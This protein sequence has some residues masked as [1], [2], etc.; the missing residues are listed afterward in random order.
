L[1]NYFKYFLILI[2]DLFLFSKAKAQCDLLDPTYID[3]VSVDPETGNIHISWYQNPSNYTV[4]YQILMHNPAMNPVWN[5]ISTNTGASNIYNLLSGFNTAEKSFLFNVTAIDACGEKSPFSFGISHSTI[6]VSNEYNPCERSIKL[7][8]NQYINWTAGVGRYEIWKKENNIHTLVATTNNGDTTYT[9]TGVTLFTNL[10]LYIRA[11]DNSSPSKTSTSN[12]TSVFTDFPRNP[13]FSYIRHASVE[14]DNVTVLFHLDP[15]ADIQ[16]YLLQ[17]NSGLGFQTIE[18][19]SPLSLNGNNYSSLDNNVN[20]DFQS[21]SYQIVSINKC[22]SPADTSNLAKTIHLQV[23]N[24][25]S[26]F[27]NLLNWNRYESW[28]GDVESYKIYRSVNG[29][30]SLIATVDENTT[31]F[32]DDVFNLNFSVGE[33]CYY[34]EANEGPGNLFA[35]REKSY[36]NR[37]CVEQKPLVFVPNA[38]KPNGKNSIWKPVFSYLPPENYRLMIFNRWGEKIFEIHDPNIGWDGDSGNAP[39]GAYVYRI[40]FTS[41]GELLTKLGTVTIIK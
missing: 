5:T 32:Y 19:F 15:A 23:K 40:E 10:D 1:A 24:I 12:Y 9:Y 37:V 13:D 25:E 31:Q 2:I 29:V 27:K 39:A 26:D 6:F 16:K 17:R 4:S 36:S 33:F 18:E 8:W 3:S 11:I 28:S 20:P 21:Y 41:E 34:I 35:F 38:F 30:F 7:K 22:G 14:N